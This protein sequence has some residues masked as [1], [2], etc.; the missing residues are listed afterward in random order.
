MG[1]TETPKVACLG[2][3]KLQFLN[4]FGGRFG[5]ESGP[6]R[7]P[8]RSPKLLVLAP[9]NC[10]F[11]VGLGVVLGR[12][13]TAT[14]PT[15]PPIN[16]TAQ[17]LRRGGGSARQRNWIEKSTW[18]ICASWGLAKDAPGW[19]GLGPS[20]G[21]GTYRAIPGPGPG[22]VSWGLL[23]PSGPPRIFDFLIESGPRKISA[24]DR[25]EG[26]NGTY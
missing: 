3:P 22:W 18:V 4:W 14:Q 2:T 24:E 7:E 25:G 19:P 21:T 23:G 13:R 5:Q 16:L 8:P 1:A 20:R 11:W 26:R 15:Q 12:K 6:P 9:R 17:L 10:K